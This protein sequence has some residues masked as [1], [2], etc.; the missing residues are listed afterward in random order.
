MEESQDNQLSDITGN[1]ELEEELEAQLD[2]SLPYP[3]YSPKDNIFRFFLKILGLKN[4]TK[5][6]FLTKEET[7][8]SRLSSRSYLELANYADKE[9]LKLIKD[10]FKQ[11]AEI[12]SATSMGREGKFLTTSVTQI[13]KDQKIGIAQQQNQPRFWEKSKPQEHQ[14]TGG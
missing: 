14:Y 10:Y 5:V 13:R 9:G 6:A 8:K 3:N 2:G 11:R 7:G 1:P 12:L 4:S